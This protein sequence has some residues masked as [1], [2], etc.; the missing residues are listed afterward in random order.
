M[1]WQE[2]QYDQNLHTVLSLFCFVFAVYCTEQIC[3][4]QNPFQKS[5]TLLYTSLV[6]PVSNQPS[7]WFTETSLFFL[8]QFLFLSHLFFSFLLGGSL[9]FWLYTKISTFSANMLPVIFYYWRVYG[10]AKTLHWQGHLSRLEDI[11]QGKEET[12]RPDDIST[13]LLSDLSPFQN[14]LSARQY[15]ACFV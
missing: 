11:Y 6:N 9:K 3:W 7:L 4:N 8:Y 5:H 1:G 10:H 12:A 13:Y 2:F 14:D 15:I